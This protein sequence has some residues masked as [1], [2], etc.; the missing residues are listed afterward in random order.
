MT[1]KL[2]PIIVITHFNGIYVDR[3]R[4][5]IKIHNITYFNKIIKDKKLPKNPAHTHTLP[6][7][8]DPAYNRKIEEAKPLIDYER[9]KLEQEYE[10]SYRQ[11]IGGLI[12]GMLTCRPDISLP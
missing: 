8:P 4:D 11:A 3:T 7:D 9:D 5:Y 6:M 1:I 10:F 2:K 12:Y